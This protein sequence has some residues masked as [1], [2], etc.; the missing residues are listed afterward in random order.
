MTI[1]EFFDYVKTSKQD[2]PVRFLYT[3]Q[4]CEEKAGLPSFE[5]EARNEPTYGIDIQLRKSG[6]KKWD[7]RG[8]GYITADWLERVSLVFPS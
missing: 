3:A 7:T 8:R 1:Q 5:F 2:M 4:E 6:H